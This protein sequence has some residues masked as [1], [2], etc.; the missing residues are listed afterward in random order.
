MGM[1]RFPCEPQDSGCPL[2]GGACLHLT[3]A[4]ACHTTGATRGTG[5]RAGSDLLPVV[6]SR[7]E[8]PIAES[9]PDCVHPLRPPL[10]PSHCVLPIASIPIASI[11][12]ASIPIP[13]SIP[14]HFHISGIGTAHTE[15]ERSHAIPPQRAPCPAAVFASGGP[16][17]HAPKSRLWR[18]VF[19]PLSQAPTRRP[20]SQCLAQSLFSLRHCVTVW[21][22]RRSEPTNQTETTCGRTEKPRACD[23]VL[24]VYIHSNG[25]GSASSR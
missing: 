21:T 22:L 7:D 3:R 16:P 12:I 6:P 23:S 19:P 5:R 15:R 10:R 4:G 24:L 8:C 2:P 20:P 9:N 18:D 14:S 17:K 13:I 1:L 25:A 11:P